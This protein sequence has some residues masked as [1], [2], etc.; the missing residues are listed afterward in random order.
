MTDLLDKRRTEMETLVWETPQLINI[1]FERF[2]SE[3]ASMRDAI[4]DNTLRLKALERAM[5]LI[6][7]DMRDLRSGVT[8]QLVEQDKRRAGLE[9]KVG[10]IEHRLDGQDKRLGGIEQT[11]AEILRRLPKA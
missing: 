7:A 5:M 4:V 2:D 9:Q 6:Q 1:R 3:F 10:E 8:P 11:L